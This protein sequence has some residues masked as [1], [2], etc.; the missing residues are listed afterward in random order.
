MFTIQG[1]PIVNGKV[2]GKSSNKTV[3]R[4]GIIGAGIMAVCC[5]APGLVILLSAA[6]TASI[7][8]YLDRALFPLLGLIAVVTVLGLL[9]MR[10]RNNS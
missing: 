1:S 4:I 6:G 2:N 9:R 7:M 8:V 10:Q 5:I 3:Y